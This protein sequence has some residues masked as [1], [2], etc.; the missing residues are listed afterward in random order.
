[1][2]L[3]AMCRQE[4]LATSPTMTD[5]SVKGKQ[6]KTVGAAIAQR[7][8]S[9]GVAKVPVD[10]SNAASVLRIVVAAMRS[11]GL[12]S[13]CSPAWRRPRAAG[14][15][16]SLPQHVDVVWQ[17]LCQAE[18]LELGV[19]P[20]DRLRVGVDALAQFGVLG[21]HDQHALA[22]YNTPNSVQTG[23]DP[24]GL[25]AF[26]LERHLYSVRCGGAVVGD[27]VLMAPLVAL[28]AGTHAGLALLPPGTYEGN[29]GDNG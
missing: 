7:W 17:R 18:L 21:N 10:A 2:R 25:L 27:D 29:R 8:C 19:E 20:V 13:A 26:R 1:M 9:P 14:S 22:W 28:D 5:V 16:G 3:D 24:C 15:S 12:S 4:V 6:P 11:D 23:A